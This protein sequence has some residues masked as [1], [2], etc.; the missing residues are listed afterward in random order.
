[1]DDEVDQ[2]M[3][4]LHLTRMREVFDREMTRATKAKSP[5]RDV[6]ANLLREQHAWQRQRA[7]E[8]R[9]KTARLPDRL[10]LDTFPF[11]QQ[12]G[13][14][15]A[16]IKQLGELDFVSKAEN[17]VFIGPTGVGKTGLASAILLKALQNGYRGLFVKAQDLFDEMYASLADRS[18]RKLLDRLMTVDVLLIDEMG[19]LTLRP[20][21]SNL[22][23]KLMEERYSRRT[24]IVTTNLEYDDWYGFLGKKEMV[25]ALL[26]RLCHHCHTL[27][28]EGPSLR[29]PEIPA[30]PR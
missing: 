2:L 26:S 28:I 6:V 11:K 24:T 1:M 17:L 29:T 20:E 15:A 30:G 23:F 21:Q 10:S 5:Y 9:V 3:K 18:S 16:A 19:Y 7:F 22:F 13:V 27:R 14:N 25:G 12:P 8:Y 4:N